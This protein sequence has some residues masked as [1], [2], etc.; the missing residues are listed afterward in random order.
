MLPRA[1]ARSCHKTDEHIS[2]NTKAPKVALDRIVAP[3]PPLGT[4]ITT[5]RPRRCTKQRVGTV[6]SRL[7]HALSVI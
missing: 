6:M 2:L 7:L 1:S 4:P 3:R 5:T